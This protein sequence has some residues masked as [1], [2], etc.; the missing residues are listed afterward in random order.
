MVFT[1]S[2][3]FQV[4]LPGRPGTVD[5]FATGKTHLI[6]DRDTKCGDG[7]GQ[8]L[9]SAGV[10]IVFCP[11]CVPQCNV[12]ASNEWCCIVRLTGR[13]H[14]FFEHTLPETDLRPNMI[15]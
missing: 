1:L 15:P 5:G 4:G 8:T 9:E 3:N 13:P 11:P 12:Y 10:G 7:F 2:L 6:T 14:E